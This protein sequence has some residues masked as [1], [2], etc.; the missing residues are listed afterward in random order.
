[1]RLAG[2]VAAPARAGDHRVA[3]AFQDA[4]FLRGTVAENL[5]LGLKLRGVESRERAARISEVAR[6]CGVA[7][8]LDRDARRLSAGEAQRANLARAL[9]LRAPLTLLDEPLAGLDRIGRTHLL[10]DLPH[11]LETFAATT[12]LVTHDR[13]EALRLADELVVLV[14]GR[15]HGAGPK[16]EVFDRPP[17]REAAELLGY[18]VLEPGGGPPIALGPNALRPGPGARTFT[19]VVQRVIEMGSHVHVVGRIEGRTGWAGRADLRLPADA[20]RPAVGA[21]VEVSAERWAELPG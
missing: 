17:S 12:I 9:A 10:D 4:I 8:L 11:L 19:L 21:R 7:H 16:R 2:D 20:A 13:E 5:E 18:S 15:V 14:D 1:M 6:E 3:F